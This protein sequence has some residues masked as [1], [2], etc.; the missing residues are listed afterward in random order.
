ML[1]GDVGLRAMRRD[2]YRT[3]PRFER[4]AQVFNGS[5]PWDEKDGYFCALHRFR[6]GRDPLAIRVSAESVIEAR[7]REAVAMRDLESV[8]AGAVQCPRNRPHLLDRVL[9]TNGMHA[10]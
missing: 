6:H 5:D 4:L 3:R 1:L 8:D 2:P 10:I 9:V 7:P